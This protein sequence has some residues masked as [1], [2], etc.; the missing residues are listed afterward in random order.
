MKSPLYISRCLQNGGRFNS[1]SVFIP[2]SSS[3]FHCATLEWCFCPRPTSCRE[4][5]LSGSV[6]WLTVHVVAVR[7]LLSIVQTVW[8]IFPKMLQYVL[9]CI[10]R[11]QECVIKHAL[12]SAWRVQVLMQ[13]HSH[14]RP[15]Q[16]PSWAQYFH[17]RPWPW[18]KQGD[19]FYP[20]MISEI[21][22]V[23]LIYTKGHI[24]VTISHKGRFWLYLSKQ[25]WTQF[26]IPLIA[27]IFKK[28]YVSEYCSS[29]LNHF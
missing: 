28:I 5:F 25:S 23:K 20:S 4:L 9:H 26:K 21:I 15:A 19:C 1:L 17:I 14:V 8:G 12:R 18:N 11:I 29:E 6:C 3:F 7:L 13:F 24:D 27:E 10:K 2:S 16:V 22:C